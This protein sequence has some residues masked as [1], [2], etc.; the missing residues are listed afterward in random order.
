MNN[1]EQKIDLLLKLKEMKDSGILT[2]EEFE[3]KKAEILN[4]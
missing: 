1:E 4:K 2:D 3:I